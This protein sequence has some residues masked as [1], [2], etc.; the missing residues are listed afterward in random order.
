MPSNPTKTHH[1]KRL[2][3]ENIPLEKT[4]GAKLLLLSNKALP[5]VFKGVE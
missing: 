2:T 5:Y 1:K 3:N 4:A